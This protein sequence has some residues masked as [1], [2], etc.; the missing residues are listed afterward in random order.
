M[1]GNFVDRD[2]CRS[3][4]SCGLRLPARNP[5]P[6]KPFALKLQACRSTSIYR[7]ANI[8]RCPRELIFLR[9]VTWQRCDGRGRQTVRSRL[10]TAEPIGTAHIRS[11]IMTQASSIQCSQDSLFTSSRNFLTLLPWY[12]VRVGPNLVTAR[13]S[14]ADVCIRPS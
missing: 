8:R 3:T 1:T 9:S 7:T 4:R 11:E 12:I 13:T 2:L 5:A 10:R 6:R 14:G